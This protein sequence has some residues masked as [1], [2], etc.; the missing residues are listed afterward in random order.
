LSGFDLLLVLTSAL[1]HAGWS[2]AIKHS[3]DPLAFNL[4][5]LIAP[6]AALAALLPWLDL[7]E[8]PAAAWMLLAAAGCAHG[9][10]FY[11]M[12][13]AYEHGDLSL[14]Y[15][16]ARSTPAFLPLIAVPLLGEPISAAGALGIA[17]VVA[18]M[19]VVQVGEGVRWSA[20][21]G[22]GVRFAYLTLAATIAYS[23]LDKSA[24]TVLAAGA[25][26][27]P[28][29]RA[30]FYCLALNLACG[31]IFAP[32]VLRR[33]GAGAIAA[34]A[35]REWGRATLAA[36]VSFAGYS[37]ILRALETA[38]VSYVVAARQTSVLFAVLLG[39]IALGERPGRAR[40][41]GAAATVLG[42]ALIGLAGAPRP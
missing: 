23:L 35:R 1:L 39:A 24:M 16:I 28:V 21:T 3:R 37:L 12:S 40:I 19:W 38:P 26:S 2:A 27:S 10:Y 33:R 6:A 18:G 22:L 8:I 5:Q 42:V 29:P 14:V 20:F 30:A 31:L 9:G 17:I 4:L 13:R 7:R 41:L 34:A 25:W 11:W 32:L 36:V 15:P